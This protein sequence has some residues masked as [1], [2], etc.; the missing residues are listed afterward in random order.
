MN[1]LII[2]VCLIFSLSVTFSQRAIAMDANL[3]A[4]W[5]ELT[6][7]DF[8]KAVAKSGKV[9]ILPTGIIEKHG[10]HMPTGT[11]LIDA[12]HRFLTR[13]KRNTR[14]FFRHITWAR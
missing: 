4:Q 1:K 8:V 10:P 13:S 7:P 6:G 11:D 9:C 14:L 5:E 2:I 3:A 12:R